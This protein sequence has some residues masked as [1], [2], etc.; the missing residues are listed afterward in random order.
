MAASDLIIGLGHKKRVGKDTLGRMLKCDLI[1]RGYDV[2]CL[3][4]ADALKDCAHTLF[5]HRGLK[6]KEWYDDYPFERGWVLSGIE[7][8]PRQIWIELGNAVRRIDPDLWVKKV[9][10]RIRRQA[11]C[12]A[13]R[14]RAFIITD[15]RFPNEAHAIHSWGGVLVK[16]NRPALEPTDD[17]SDCALDYYALWDMYVNNGGSL[18]NLKVAASQL[19]ETLISLN[20]LETQIRKINEQS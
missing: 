13:Y 1:Q 8:T 11:R 9:V 15:V 18:E 16:V 10:D 2:H 20:H 4:F 6:E 17:P 7:K 14:P 3:A 12:F 19:V 5:G